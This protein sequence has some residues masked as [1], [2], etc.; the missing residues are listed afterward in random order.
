MRC[1]HILINMRLM[2]LY[3]ISKVSHFTHSISVSISLSVSVFLFLSVCLCLS[4][5]VSV[6]LSLY[7]SV[8]VSLLLS[9]SLFFLLFLALS[10]SF[11]LFLALSL[12]YLFICLVTLS[13]RFSLHYLFVYLYLYFSGMDKRIC[14]HTFIPTYMETCTH[15]LPYTHNTCTCVHIHD[16]LKLIREIL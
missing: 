11:L 3:F 5:S 7:L 10:L 16:L 1:G 2:S 12:S 15:I 13:L 6:C 8:F 14:M 4:S 9:L